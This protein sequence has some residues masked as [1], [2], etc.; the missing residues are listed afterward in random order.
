MRQLIYTD[1]DRLT[2]LANAMKIPL[3][4][5]KCYIAE[6]KPFRAQRT[7]KQNRLLFMWLNLISKETGN[8][9]DTLLEYFKQKHLSW[10]TKEV[11][12]ED[13]VE[14]ISTSKL[15]TAEFT[16]FLEAIRVQMIQD[17]AIV[18]PSPGEAGW[19]EFYSQ[20]GDTKTD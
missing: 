17:Y 11:F 2:F 6:I 16:V 1:Q 14:R 10:H 3:N 8:D 5:K 15:N 19:E 12:G 13:V 18:L 4:G 20:Y 9:V 7:V